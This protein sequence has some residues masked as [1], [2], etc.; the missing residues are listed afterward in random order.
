MT[1]CL[2]S[3]GDR[4]MMY[5]DWKP[6]IVRH[7]G[8]AYAFRARLNDKGRVMVQEDTIKNRI[9]YTRNGRDF[10]RDIPVKVGTNE[11]SSVLQAAM[12]QAA[13]ELEV[14]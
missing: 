6:M 3:K 2:S 13:N 8:K 10:M 9:H 7:G 12:Q 14:S 11:H 4:Q 5:L 1:T